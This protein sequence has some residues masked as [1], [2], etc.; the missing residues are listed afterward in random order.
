MAAVNVRHLLATA[1]PA[2]PFIPVMSDYGAD[3]AC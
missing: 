1:A 2:L 3:E